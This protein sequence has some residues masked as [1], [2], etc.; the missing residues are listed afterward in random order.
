MLSWLGSFR[1]ERLRL[2]SNYVLVHHNQL[3]LIICLLLATKSL[4]VMEGHYEDDGAVP[5]HI[6]PV[7]Y[8][9]SDEWG[10]IVSEIGIG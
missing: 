2:A 10:H 1:V 9:V 5:Q 8:V 3:W 6:D 4:I 7:L